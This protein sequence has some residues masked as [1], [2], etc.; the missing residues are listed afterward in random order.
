M[1]KVR[2]AL[3][4][5]QQGRRRER[6]LEMS[7]EDCELLLLLSDGNCVKIAMLLTEG[8]MLMINWRWILWV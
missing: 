3:D 1:F 4:E 7:G 6:A 5:V 2:A 8:R